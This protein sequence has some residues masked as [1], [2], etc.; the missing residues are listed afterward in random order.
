MKK[1]KKPVQVDLKAL[2]K[3]LQSVAQKTKPHAT[4]VMTL[5]AILIIGIFASVPK[6]QNYFGSQS[7]KASGLG[8]I[9][10]IE[11]PH[12][13][14]TASASI[15]HHLIIFLSYIIDYI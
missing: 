14:A 4:A 1:K 10:P 6:V 5:A 7:S 3:L 2:R 8:I 9:N 13:L 11:S 12:F 15:L